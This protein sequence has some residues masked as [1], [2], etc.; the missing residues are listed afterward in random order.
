MS[1]KTE[2]QINNPTKATRLPFKVSE[3]VDDL[4]KA[5]KIKPARYLKELVIK[6]LIKENILSIDYKFNE[7]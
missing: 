2:Y 5:R 3:K 4:C 7:D 1:E 6:D